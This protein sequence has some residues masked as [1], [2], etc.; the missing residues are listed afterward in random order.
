VPA[1]SGR[2]NLHDHHVRFRSRGG[3]NRRTNRITVCARHHLRAIH[4]GLVRGW[5]TAPHGIRWQLGLDNGGASA[6]L[7]L[8]GD[9]YLDDAEVMADRLIHKRHMAT[10]LAAWI[11]LDGDWDALRRAGSHAG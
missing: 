8:L 10:R 1:C 4:W 11:P 9:R 3:D 2:R 5:G 7:E 6:L